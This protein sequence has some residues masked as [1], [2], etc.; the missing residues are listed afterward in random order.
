MECGGNGEDRKKRL[1]DAGYDYNI[2]QNIVNNRLR[3]EN[4]YVYYTVKKGD[5]LSGIAMKYKTKVDTL[6]KWN[7]IK[8]RN[9]IYPGQKLRVK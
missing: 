3:P 5:T 7:N 1:T 4:N 8:N 9:L 6:V 2:I